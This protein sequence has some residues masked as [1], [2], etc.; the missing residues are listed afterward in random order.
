MRPRGK[1]SLL[2]TNVLLRYLLGDDPVQ[3]PRARVLFNR[4]EQSSERCEIPEVTLVETVWV[5]SKQAGVPRGIIA[6]DLAGI[7]KLPGI[8]HPRK[9]VWMDA[10][11]LFASTNCD[12]ADCL[13]AAQ[14]KS[15]GMSVTSFDADF[16]KLGCVWEEPT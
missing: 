16:R 11:T 3:S 13:L 6:S 10:L 12:M 7:L 9:R 2:D 4:L 14:A 15:R 8:R 5:L 1:A